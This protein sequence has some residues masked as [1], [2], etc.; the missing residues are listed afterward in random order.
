M[1]NIV[2]ALHNWGLEIGYMVGGL[3]GALI[4]MG[5]EKRKK[6]PLWER[7]LIAFTGI[8]TA[9]YLTPLL[10]YTFGI[11]ERV[12]YGMSFIIGYMGLNGLGLIIDFGRT[13]LKKK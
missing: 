10:I 11:S 7:V 4:F 9:N 2:D 13:K 8:L 3:F 5:N 12:Q 6:R 1:K